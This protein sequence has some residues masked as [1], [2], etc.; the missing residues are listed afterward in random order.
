MFTLTLVTY[1]EI[2]DY[3]TNTIHENVIYFILNFILKL[4]ILLYRAFSLQGS[5]I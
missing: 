3:L 1:F 5:N 2:I 4:N